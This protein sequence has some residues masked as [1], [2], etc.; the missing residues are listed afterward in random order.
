MPWDEMKEPIIHFDYNSDKASFGIKNSAEEK[1]KD[2]KDKELR[3]S[4]EEKTKENEKTK[5]KELCGSDQFT[6][7]VKSDR[8]QETKRDKETRDKGCRSKGDAIKMKGLQSENIS[9]GPNQ[10]LRFKGMGN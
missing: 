1:T 2:L 7:G 5:D 3:N 8:K 6:Y 9:D 4:A 10:N